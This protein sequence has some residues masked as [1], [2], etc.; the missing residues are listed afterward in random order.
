MQQTGDVAETD[1]TEPVASTP[2]SSLAGT[3][4]PEATSDAAWEDY[5][6]DPILKSPPEPGAPGRVPPGEDLNLHIGWDRF[7][8]L[9]LAVCRNV[10]GLHQVRF[11]RYGVQGQAQHGIDLAGRAPD[12]QHTVVQ[13]KD[14]K[15]FTTDVFRKAVETFADGRR[16]FGAKHLIVAT[17]ASTEPTQFAD[18]LDALQE[19]HPDLDL[20]LWGSEQINEHLRKFGNVVAQFWTRETAETFCTDA[21]TAGVPIPLPDRLEQAQRI[22]IGPLNTNT[23]APLLQQA[24]AQHITE[25][26]ASAGLYADLAGRLEEAGF[27]GHATVLRQRQ[28]DALQT[29]RLWQ[30]AGDLAAQLAVDALHAGDRREPR[31][32]A[33]R[34]ERLAAHAQA[35]GS[36]A[37]ASIKRHIQLVRSALEAVLHPLG[38]SDG[39]R[40]ALMDPADSEPLYQP[41]LVLLLA[42]STLVS[43]PDRLPTLDGLIR[44]AIEQHSTQAPAVGA[45]DAVMRLRMI[46]AEYDPSER[47]QL[48]HL[49]RRHMVTGRLAAWVN[50]RE[51]RRCAWESSADSAVEHWR[52]AVYDGIHA[53]FTEDASDWL[54]AIRSVNAL[55]GPWEDLDDEHRLASALRATGTARLLGRAGSPREQAL[56]AR[57]G[58]QDTEAVLSARRW[59]ADA[60]VTGDWT[61]ELQALEFLADL[62]AENQA[63]D[64]A[65]ELYVRAGCTN[66]LQE[67]A[68]A[69]EDYPLHRAPFGDAPWWVLQAQATLVEAQADLIDDATAQELMGVMMA[70][71]ERGR[72]GELTES[73]TRTLTHQAT[74]TA[75]A[76]ADRGTPEQAVQLLDLLAADV[77][78]HASQARHSDDSH[79]SACVAVAKAHPSGAKSALTRL[80]DLAE[81]GVQKALELLV[82]DELTGLIRTAEGDPLPAKG[83]GLSQQDLVEL[84]GR[85]G[86]LD[87]KGLYLADVARALFE[88]DHPKVL[89]RAE[90]ARDRILQHPTPTPGAFDIG[91]SL[92][93]DSFQVT[94]ARA[95]PD[96]DRKACLERVLAIAGDA[97]EIVLTRQDALMAAKNLVASRPEH[98][99]QRTF[100][101]VIGLVRGE[102]TESRLS[103]VLTDSPHPLSAFRL[104]VES[105]S[106]RGPALLLAQAAASDPEEHEWIR[107]QATELLRSRD[108]NDLHAAAMALC[109]LPDEQ[110]TGVDPALLASHNHV[111]IRQAS[112]VLC[113]RF[114]DRHVKTALNLVADRDFRVRQTLADHASHAASKGAQVE[115]VRQA[116]HGDARHSVRTLAGKPTYHSCPGQ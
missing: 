41:V 62:Y 111:G 55:F 103:E 7:E 18:E 22:L 85:I 114:P 27:H 88:P 14:Y 72:A 54:Y 12:G 116:L 84:C 1:P 92:V 70:L 24:E 19:E 3:D 56:S 77:P 28:L 113:M 107:Q 32:L 21:P 91:T 49:A 58:G 29:A 83:S 2:T 86:G 48:R 66:Q 71:A 33:S 60:I 98:E 112:A 42:E 89:Q 10:L 43:A 79:A 34:L 11:R 104:K 4:P 40:A 99:R 38:A 100:K 78:R 61:D 44:A 94:R 63:P 20:E 16:P 50:A 39:L 64:L 13:C 51:A 8:K 67:L 59:L 47:T 101:A 26:E 90:Q 115:A 108:G 75:C 80:F 102:H 9:M 5:L 74:T 15:D 52:D 53:G 45:E 35:D 105:V 37:A 68:A 73:P 95:L 30:Q 25:P 69:V 110:A 106:L 17:S 82:G 23:V 57:G 36:N 65:A 6:R 87:D 76:L 31:T 93:P 46:R 81:Q 97:Q 109:R 96:P